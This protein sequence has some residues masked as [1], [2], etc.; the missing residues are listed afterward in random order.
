M[1]KSYDVVVF[2]WEGT[3]G[4]TLGQILNAFILEV[5][6]LHLG[7]INQQVVRENL[8]LGLVVA[9]KKLFPQLT[10]YQH[11]QLVEAIQYR[12][13]LT[14]ADIYLMPGAKAVVEALYK[15]GVTLAIATNKS[16]H[17]LQRALQATGLEPF[18]TVTRSAGQVAAKPAPQMLEEIIEVLGVNIPQVL[19]IGDTVN[20]IE[21]ARCIGVDVIGVDFYH[22]Q[23]I[24]LRAAGAMAVFDN[25][26]SL[27]HY[28]DLR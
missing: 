24:N 3:L 17:S 26:P 21:M 12:A 2:D 9:V 6:R 7:T 18:F 1:S 27:A 19:M 16:R 8:I 28:L 23:D 11:E 22:Q 13:A 10:N 14:S 4:D 5:E 15:K 20:D 25:Y